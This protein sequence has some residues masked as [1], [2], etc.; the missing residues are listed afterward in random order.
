MRQQ[1]LEAVITNSLACVKAS[2]NYM[3]RGDI[4]HARDTLE[5]AIELL[6]SACKDG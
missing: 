2:A 1:R 4:K 3:E 5:R 6:N